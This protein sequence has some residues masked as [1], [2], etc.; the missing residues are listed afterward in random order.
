MEKLVVKDSLK[1][2][3]HIKAIVY[4]ANGEIFVHHDEHNTIDTGL[5]NHYAAILQASADK[6]LDN[7]FTACANPAASGKDGI[8]YNDPAVLLDS[9]SFQCTGT[10][11][12]VAYP[13]GWSGS[14]ATRTLT[15][16]FTGFAKTLDTAAYIELGF[17]HNGS[18]DFATLFAHASSW[19]SLTL[20]AADILILQW[21][22]T[23]S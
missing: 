1:I 11:P 17:N 5:L 8:A 12:V 13:V 14:G 20:A 23:I 15:G 2:E 7:L 9:W 19:V 22:L 21:T 18:Y 3:G 4:R 6:A 10:S 16:A